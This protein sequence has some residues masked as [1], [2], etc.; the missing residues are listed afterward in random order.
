MGADR[1]GNVGGAV[2]KNAKGGWAYRVDH[3]LRENFE[4]TVGEI[5]LA[6]LKDIGPGWVRAAGRQAEDLVEKRV[7][8]SCFVTRKEMPVGDGVAQH[9]V[10]CILVAAGGRGYHSDDALPRTLSRG[11]TDAGA[12]CRRVSQKRGRRLT[13]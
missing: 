1:G 9:E 11:R 7:L 8:A 4:V 3:S 12:Q 13:G 2:E 5:F 6:N 10:E